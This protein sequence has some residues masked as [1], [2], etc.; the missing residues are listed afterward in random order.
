M[1]NWI[2]WRAS[3]P[4]MLLLIVVMKKETNVMMVERWYLRLDGKVRWYESD[5]VGDD[6]IDFEALF[7]VGWVFGN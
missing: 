1:P 2:A 5:E 4:A 3:T 7:G 6:R